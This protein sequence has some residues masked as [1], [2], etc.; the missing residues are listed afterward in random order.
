MNAAEI[1]QTKVMVLCDFDGTITRQ[2]TLDLLYRNFAACGYQYADAWTR[3]EIGTR[4]ELRLTFATVSASRGEMEA[5]LAEK[6]VFDPGVFDLIAFCRQR[7]YEFGVVSDGLDWVID[8][9]F[10]RYGITGVEVYAN[11]VVW[12][13]DGMRFEFPHYSDEF[14]MRGTAKPAIIHEKQA[15]GLKIAFVGDGR[16]DT[17]AVWAADVIY[18][19]DELAHYCRENGLRAIEYNNLEDVVANW[20]EM[21]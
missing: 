5:M 2:G 4:E 20:Q 9:L 15:Q 19:K 1:S 7:G 11:H 12:S 17:D 18:A 13:P 21:A 6:V 14:P 8:F 10:A 16:S 3:G